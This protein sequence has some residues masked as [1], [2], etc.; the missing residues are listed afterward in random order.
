MTPTSGAR[1]IRDLEAMY[2]KALKTPDASFEPVGGWDTIS[3]DV[4]ARG[5]G[6]RGIILVVHE[7]GV[8]HVFNVINKD[9]RVIYLDGQSGSLAK[10]ETTNVASEAQHRL[11]HRIAAPP[12]CRGRGRRPLD[13]DT[14]AAPVRARRRPT[15]VRPARQAGGS[16]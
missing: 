5:P 2:Q 14:D 7:K 11:P 1:L 16:R 15:P 8:G 3:Q 4:A 12:A 6:A 9:G 10:L 13:R